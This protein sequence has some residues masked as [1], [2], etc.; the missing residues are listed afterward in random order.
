MIFQGTPQA[1]LESNGSNGSNRSM[2]GAYLRGERTIL[3][4]GSRRPA[5]RGSIVV[6][7]ARANNLKGI[8]VTIPLGVLT[9]VTGVSGSGKSTLFN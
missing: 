3:T 8:D 9:T 2:T 4:P 7:G 5:T 6:K 1:L